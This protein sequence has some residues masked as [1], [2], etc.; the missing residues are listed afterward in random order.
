VTVVAEFV[1]H[2]RI[3]VEDAIVGSMAA[4]IK[5]V[6]ECFTEAG[7]GSELNGEPASYQPQITQLLSKY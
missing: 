2:G 6:S 3:R 4:T 1:R 5:F 7:Q